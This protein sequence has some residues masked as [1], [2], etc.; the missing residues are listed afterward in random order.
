MDRAILMVFAF[1]ALA[2]AAAPAEHVMAMTVAAP[3][4]FAAAAPHTVSVHMAHFVCDARC[5]RRWPAR[6]YWQWDQRP[7]W[8]DPWGVLQPNFWGSAE[9][10]FVPADQWAHEWHP[11]WIRHWRPHHPR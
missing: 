10:Y 8:D 7:V 4:E 2:L 5:A 3:P 6:Q 11:P 1:G 9:P